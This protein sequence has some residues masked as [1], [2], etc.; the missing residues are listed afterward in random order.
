MA[1][2][3]RRIPASVG[4]GVIEPLLRFIPYSLPRRNR[5]R[6][7]RRFVEVAALETGRRYCR[8]VSQIQPDQRRALYSE[9]FREQVCGN[10]EA[11]MLAEFSAIQQRCSD[12]IDALLA[13]DVESY[14]PHDLLVKMDI[15][16]M[17]NS[18]E[19]RSP[20][21]DHKVM[22]FAA[23]LPSRYKLR[24][25]QQKVLLKQL[26]Y[27]LLPK[28]VIDRRKMGFGVP[29]AD[30]FG[31]DLRPLLYDV[32]LSDTALARGYFRPAAVHN[33]VK[34]H[35]DGSTDNSFQLWALLFLELWHLEFVAAS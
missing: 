5:L 28:A 11:W 29:L 25:R 16:S 17:A 1:D 32:V 2:R 15:A 35:L 3:Y 9:A 18:L 4:K 21:L 12:P 10:D 22:E 31:G 23:R 33:M 30:W 6:Q 13:L 7:A 34:E 27:R 14:L 24:R 19:C 20:L 26:A 8:W